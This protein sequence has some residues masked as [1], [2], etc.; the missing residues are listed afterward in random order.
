MVKK[1]SLQ[2]RHKEKLPESE[3]RYFNFSFEQQYHN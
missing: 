2:I 3:K 1:S